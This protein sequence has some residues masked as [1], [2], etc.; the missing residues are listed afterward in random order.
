MLEPVGVQ[1]NPKR[2]ELLSTKFKEVTQIQIHFGSCVRMAKQFRFFRRLIGAPLR[3]FACVSS[4]EG[5]V[6]HVVANEFRL[7]A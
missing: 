5:P 3:V 6:L 1:L 2:E 7:N 4:I